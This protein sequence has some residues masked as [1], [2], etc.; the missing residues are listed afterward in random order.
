MPRARLR[1]PPGADRPQGLNR[2]RVMQGGRWRAVAL[3]KPRTPRQGAVIALLALVAIGGVGAADSATGSELSL[4]PFYMVV[5]VITALA[6]ASVGIAAAAWSAAVWSAVDSFTTRLEAPF[7][8]LVLNGLVRFGGQ[9]VLVLLVSAL[10]RALNAARESEAVSRA[11]LSD[12][13]HR[14]RTPVAAVRSSVEAI[15]LDGPRRIQD[16]LLANA[17]DEARHLGDLVASLLRIA[18][19]DQGEPLRPEATDPIALCKQEVDRLRWGSPLQ[20]RLEVAGEVPPAVMLDQRA[21]GETL[22]NLLDN[23][24]RHAAKLVTVRVRAD[25]MHLVIEV[26]DDGPGL[27]P[28]AESRAFDRFVTLDGNGGTGLGLA[29]A[30]QMARS[31]GGDVTYVGKAFVVTLPRSNLSI[32][33]GTYRP[34]RRPVSMGADQAAS[35]RAQPPQATV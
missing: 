34:R 3:W 16:R 11:Y 2:H 17:T 25:R 6:S 33:D 26:A 19:L 24:R 31:Q 12:Y 23:A 9:A 8:V 18:R 5:I 4:A 22:G 28:D 30:R 27:P 13:A 35:Q 29:I 21:T 7:G 32:G 20:W 10:L 1:D 14:L 15:A